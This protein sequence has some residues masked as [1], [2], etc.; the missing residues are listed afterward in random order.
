M[1][2]LTHESLNPDNQLAM[3]KLIKLKRIGSKIMDGRLIEGV[4]FEIGNLLVSLDCCSVPI[5]NEL[6]QGLDFLAVC[7]GIVNI[8]ECTVSL[9]NNT[10]PADI[11]S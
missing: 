11:G 6:I 1:I 4:A 7:H 3:I 2:I 9:E 5:D 10:F 8:K